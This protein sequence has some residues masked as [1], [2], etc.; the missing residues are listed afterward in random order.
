M[1]VNPLLWRAVGT[2]KRERQKANRAARLEAEQKAI[3][4]QRQ[5]QR[6]G[7]FAVIGLFVLGV[8]WL[9][10]QS[11]G[12]NEFE[13][14]SIPTT[15][16]DADATVPETSPPL[17]LPEIAA[18]AAGA[19]IT[20]PT[21]CPA[22]DGS[23]ERTTAFAEAPPMCI[24]PT[25]SYTAAVETTKGTFTI[26][27]N[28]EG[29]PETV[30]NFVVLAR[31]HYYDDVPFHRIIP[32][33]VIQGGDAVGQPQLG[34]GNPGYQIDDEL[35]ETAYEIGSVAMANSGPN[36][37]GSQFFVVTGNDATQL[38]LAYSNFGFVSDGLDVATAI[39]AIGTAQ[40]NPQEDVRIISV[41]ITES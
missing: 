17:D 1:T 23:S 26:D 5:T 20:G 10:S 35:P 34:A 41:T 28:A 9:I 6:F 18:P 31:Y 29:A 33:F 19:E 32:G 13:P 2:D 30:N 24:D 12:Q 39:E 11:G 37:N 8:L 21:E 4:R 22:V 14:A 7:L 15:I 36:T 38:P 40:G 3:A 25:K 16:A 27:L